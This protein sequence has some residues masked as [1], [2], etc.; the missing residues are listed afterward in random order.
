MTK[1]WVEDYFEAPP[2]ESL[3]QTLSLDDFD[4]YPFIELLFQNDGK[5][6]K[7]GTKA[8]TFSFDQ[9]SNLISFERPWKLRVHYS[10]F[11][12]RPGVAG[13]GSNPCTMC[14]DQSGYTFWFYGKRNKAFPST[15]GSLDP[16]SSNSTQQS[17]VTSTFEKSLHTY[18]YESG[19][20]PINYDDY[21][22]CKT[23]R[24][25]QAGGLYGYV[26][27]SIADNINKITIKNINF[28]PTFPNAGTSNPN[29]SSFVT[30]NT[31]NLTQLGQT[32][33]C[34]N[35]AEVPVT[36]SI[37]NTEIVVNFKFGYWY[38]AGNNN[39]SY[40]QGIAWNRIHRMSIDKLEII[41]V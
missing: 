18:E 28:A 3:K 2:R 39:G 30:P 4:S 29:A 23:V 11:A 5:E 6:I 40:Q 32:W 19:I 22:V 41:A 1:N 35:S 15:H 7:S 10:G 31:L 14:N 9:I 21:G 36:H 13:F 33:F 20:C 17:P 26:D 34:S 12:G 16:S 37:N 8:Q 25:K 27:I 38:Y 24:R